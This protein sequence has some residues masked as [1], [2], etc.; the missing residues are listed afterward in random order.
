MIHEVF[1]YCEIFYYA[2]LPQWKVIKLLIT[3]GV[4]LAPHTRIRYANLIYGT[5]KGV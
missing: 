4:V 1:D 2:V 5:L 3:V